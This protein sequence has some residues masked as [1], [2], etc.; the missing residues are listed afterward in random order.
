MAPLDPQVLDALHKFDITYEA[1]DCDPE[2]ADTAAFC[3]KY[4]IP[5][6][7]AANAIL[8]PLWRAGNGSTP[9]RRRR[10]GAALGGCGRW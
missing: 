2:F 9:D 7:R 8:V 6:E 10:P 1:M 3:A 4:D 5:V